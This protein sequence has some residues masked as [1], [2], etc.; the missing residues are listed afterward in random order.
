MKVK[1]LI[2]ILLIMLVFGF[3]FVGCFSI[4]SPTPTSIV[5]SIF[6]NYIDVKYIV[7]GNNSIMDT[8]PPK[9]SVTYS[10]SQGG[11]EQISDIEITKKAKDLKGFNEI[12]DPIIKSDAVNAIIIVQ[13]AMFPIGEFLYIS[14]QNQNDFGNTTVIIMVNNKIWKSS[15]ANGGY[16]I[17][18][19]SGYYGES[20]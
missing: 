4:G 17:A 9:V 6:A 8:N 19:A 10:N 16:S 3:T 13:Y 20:K 18:E 14:A 12:E 11:T 5:E 2:P 7:T 1:Y 15:S